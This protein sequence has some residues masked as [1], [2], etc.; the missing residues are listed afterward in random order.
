M[1]AADAVAAADTGSIIDL[2]PLRHQ[3]WQTV[4]CYELALLMKAVGIINAGIYRA[5]IHII[6]DE[7]PVLTQPDKD[8]QQERMNHIRFGLSICV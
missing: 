8:K 6:A 2:H 7:P 1:N 3:L 5:E 4:R